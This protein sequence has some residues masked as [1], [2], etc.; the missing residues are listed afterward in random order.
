MIDT[1]GFYTQKIFQSGRAQQL[2]ASME[3]YLEM[4]CRLMQT[5][6]AVRIKELSRLL[7]VK[8]SSASKMVN[9]L[10]AAGLVNFERYGEIIPTNQG[11]QLGDYLL[12]RHH[13][14]HDFLCLL[15]GS[16]NELEQTEKIE[17]FLNV[18]TVDNLSQLIDKMRAKRS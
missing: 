13:I 1:N 9:N 12:R 16:E 5:E 17:H 6:A 3:D 11:W 7:H 8:P 2:T 18:S 14:V 15:N 4:I 10:K